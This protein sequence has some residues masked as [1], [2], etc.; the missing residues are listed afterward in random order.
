MLGRLL[1]SLRCRAEAGLRAARRRLACWTRPATSPA[2]VLGVAGD[3]LRGRPAPIAENAL[4]RQQLIVLARSA[5]RPRLTPC[6]GHFTHP[7]TASSWTN[8]RPAHRRG[9]AK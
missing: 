4:L 5:N 6:A 1:R 3:L 9:P 8:G 7:P 2:L